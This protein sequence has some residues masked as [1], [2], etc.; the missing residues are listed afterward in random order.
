MSPGVARN[1]SYNEAQSP[2]LLMLLARWQQYPKFMLLLD[3]LVYRVE[4]PGELRH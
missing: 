3:G 2:Q 4:V 1:F